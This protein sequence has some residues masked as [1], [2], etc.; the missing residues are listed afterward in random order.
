M[1]AA[2]HTHGKQRGYVSK[3]DLCL[4]LRKY[5]V[6]KD[7]FEELNPGEFYVH[8]DEH[9]GCGR[10]LQAGLLLKLLL[11]LLRRP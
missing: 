4:D 8:V 3:C 6:T 10:E 2:S 9:R 1:V 11:P 7:D 5:L